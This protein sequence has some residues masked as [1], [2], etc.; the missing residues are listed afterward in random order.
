MKCHYILV[1]ALLA[2]PGR[3]RA[4]DEAPQHPKLSDSDRLQFGA[5]LATIAQRVIAALPKRYQPCEL[6]RDAA[7]FVRPETLIEG[8]AM[9][10]EQGLEPENWAVAIKCQAGL[11]IVRLWSQ[12]LTFDEADLAG[13][14]VV[15]RSGDYLHVRKSAENRMER[16]LIR[17]A[18]LPEMEAPRLAPPR[19]VDV[20][21]VG[22]SPAESVAAATK[23]ARE[24]LARKPLLE[25]FPPDGGVEK[26]AP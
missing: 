16:L 26:K 7:D 5:P 20:R 15:A 8:N 6:T 18:A 4:V 19:T 21:W 11:V 17:T 25:F 2:W 24:V 3:A 23:V 12:T 9:K 22:I 13:A 10:S 14:T 1:V